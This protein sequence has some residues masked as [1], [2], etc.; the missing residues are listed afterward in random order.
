MKPLVTLK[1]IQ[2][3]GAEQIGIYF[4]N[5]MSLNVLIRKK[6]GGKWSRT[7]QCWYLPLTR[8]SYEKVKAAICP[9]ARLHVTELKKHLEKRRQAR[10]RQPG[11]GDKVQSLPMKR[12]MKPEKLNVRSRIS[13]INKQVVPSMLEALKLKGYSSSTIKTYINEIVQLLVTIQDIPAVELKPEQLKRYLVY[14]YEKL[15]LKENTLHSRINAI[16]PVG[17]KN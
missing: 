13:S 10:L 11:Q 6:A 4:V 15:G 2:H 9:S 12:S 16:Y 1:P 8:E 7:H 17:L 5:D 14:C 3:D